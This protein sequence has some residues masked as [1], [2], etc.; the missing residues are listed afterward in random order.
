MTYEVPTYW[1]MIMDVLAS[2]M[3]QMFKFQIITHTHVFTLTQTYTHRTMRTPHSQTHFC[4]SIHTHL[5]YT[6]TIKQPALLIT[7]WQ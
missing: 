1:W 6:R 2:C 5:P 7:Q 4:S 3:C